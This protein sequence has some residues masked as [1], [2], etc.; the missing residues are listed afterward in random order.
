MGDHRIEDSNGNIILVQAGSEIKKWMLLGS[1]RGDTQVELGCTVGIREP[2]WEVLIGNE[3][4][5]V[6]IEWKVLNR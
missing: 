5:T 6:A 2:T 4:Y 1:G 3:S